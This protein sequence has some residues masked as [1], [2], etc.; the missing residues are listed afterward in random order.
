MTRPRKRRTPAEMETARRKAIAARRYH[1]K[2]KH[3]MTLEQYEELKE[4][5]GGTCYLCRRAT[6]AT[7]A[8][9]VDHD[10]AKAREECNHSHE[11]SCSNC[12]RGLLDS[13]CNEILAIARDER[14]FFSRA[15]RYLQDPPAQ[16]WLR[17]NET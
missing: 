12:W 1:L 13:H 9:A 4:F 17:R 7:R 5:Q 2:T 16:R 14:E 8:L 15:A 3:R 10:H 6:G 11:T